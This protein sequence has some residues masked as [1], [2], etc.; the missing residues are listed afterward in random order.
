MSQ[1][2]IT[3]HKLRSYMGSP[4]PYCGRAMGEQGLRS[5]PSRE[6]MLP[7]SRGGPKEG[8]N[9]IVVCLD[10]NELKS[11]STLTEFLRWLMR[12]DARRLGHVLRLV[13]W[14][15]G[16]LPEAEARW[17]M[18]QWPRPEDAPTPS[19]VPGSQPASTAP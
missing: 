19:P 9:V 13:D 1:G 3:A 5:W 7:I 14:L 2:Y 18:G 11:N 17:L 8:N 16:E 10:C 6:H 15:L 12:R 4:C